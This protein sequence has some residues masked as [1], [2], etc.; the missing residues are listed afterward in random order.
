MAPPTASTDADMAVFFQ[1]PKYAVVGASTNPAKYGYKV[2]KWYVA[3][4]LPVTPVN[5]TAPDIEGHPTVGSLRHLDSPHDTAV[6]F[7]T[8][9]RVTLAA[10]REAK[11]A[12][13]PSVWLQ[14]GTFDDDVL[15]F[16]RDNFGAVLAGDGGRGGEGWCVLVDGDRGLQGRGGGGGGGK[17]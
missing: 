15:A 14:P 1:S 8:P 6:S 2:F 13:V 5:P 11:D 4:A 7:I 10:L 3:R 9:P 16:A 17:L 12:G